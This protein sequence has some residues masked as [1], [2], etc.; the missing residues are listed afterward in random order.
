M[1]YLVKFNSGNTVEITQTEF[2]AVM[3]ALNYGLNFAEISN[4]VKNEVKRDS[5]FL[6]ILKNVDCITKIQK[7]NN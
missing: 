2:N 4:E 3:Y 6:L 7:E 5:S 1:N